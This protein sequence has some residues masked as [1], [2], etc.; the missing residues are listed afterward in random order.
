MNI[1]N[2]N[3]RMWCCCFYIG[4]KSFVWNLWKLNVK[5]VLNYLRRVFFKWLVISL[6]ELSPSMFI[7]LYS[8][9]MFYVMQVKIQVQNI[10]S[11]VFKYRNALHYTTHILRIEGVCSIQ[12]YSDWQINECW[13]WETL[14]EKSHSGF[15]FWN[16]FHAH[17]KFFIGR[18]SKF[19]PH[20]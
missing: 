7:F 13:N 8:K 9:S 3:C 18:F 17:L 2:H 11:H 19:V 6:L 15:M 12:T 14:V 10:E 1:A 16:V 20:F 5:S 4:W